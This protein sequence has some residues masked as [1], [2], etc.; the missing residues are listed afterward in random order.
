MERPIYSNACSITKNDIGN[1]VVLEFIHNYPIS[2]INSE[3]KVTT[4]G[5]HETVFKTVMTI[6]SVKAFANALNSILG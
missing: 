2:D 3:G 1:E 6:D 5:G 4:I